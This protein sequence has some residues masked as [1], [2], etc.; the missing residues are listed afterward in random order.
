MMACLTLRNR[1]KDIEFDT[2]I[3]TSLTAPT[4]A[5]RAEKKLGELHSNLEYETVVVDSITSLSEA[6]MNQILKLNGRAGKVP[7]LQDWLQQMGWLRNFILRAKA[8]PCHVIFIAHEYLEKDEYTGRTKALPLVTGKLASSIGRLFD[9]VYY[10][11]VKNTGKGK[12][13]FQILVKADGIRAA[14]TRMGGDAFDLHE[15]PD[16]N[17]LIKKVDS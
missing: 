2:F 14:K 6:G 4:A 3:D 16:Y 9:E 1:E 7:Q 13:E 11:V 17:H 15:V 10:T 5:T 8:L 12:S